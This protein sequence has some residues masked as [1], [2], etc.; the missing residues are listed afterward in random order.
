MPAPAPRKSRKVLLLSIGA[1]AVVVAVVVAGVLIFT[2]N[3]DDTGAGTGAGAPTAGAAVQ[4]YLEA[5]ARG[6]AATALSFSAAQVPDKTL[7]TDE[8]L[9]TQIEKTP[10]TN[11]KILDEQGARVHV[12]AEFGG[13]KSDETLTLPQPADG[14]GWKLKSGVMTV[15]IGKDNGLYSDKLLQYVTLLGKPIPKSGKAYAFPGWIDLGSSN[16]NLDITAFH[17]MG[18]GASLKDLTFTDEVLGVQMKISDAGTK[19]VRDAVKAVAD[20]CAKSKQLAPPNCPQ[21]TGSRTDLVEGT[22][23][24]TAPTNYDD[25]IVDFFDGPTGKVQILGRVEF[26]VTVQTTSG[27]P[28][29]GSLPTGIF[30]EADMTQ[31]PP[32]ISIHK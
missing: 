16:P 2:G 28:D 14:E 17:P 10:I 13:K 22:A 18:N 31:N 29:Q 5:L 21:D 12:T 7:L 1:A 24:W 26:T 20:E 23:Q 11:I 32:T 15:D 3:G 30:G 6:D 25:V 19:A 8:V 9:K 27:Q 4:G